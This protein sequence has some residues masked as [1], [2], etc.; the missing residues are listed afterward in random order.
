[1]EPW[2]LPPLNTVASQSHSCVIRR[3]LTGE[4]G[5]PYLLVQEKVCDSLTLFC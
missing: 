1:M 2:Q 5:I 4:A 3:S